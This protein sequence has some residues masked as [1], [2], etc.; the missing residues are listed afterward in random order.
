M[1]ILSLTSTSTTVTVVVMSLMVVKVWYGAALNALFSRMDTAEK[2]FMVGVFVGFLGEAIDN[3]YWLLFWASEYLGA[4]QVNAVMLEYGRMFNLPFR[5][6]AGIIAAYCHIRA[7]LE[8]SKVGGSR[9]K[10]VQRTSEWLFGASA[11]GVV[12]AFTMY[13]IAH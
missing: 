12:V 4:K 9:A 5:Q 8:F 3:A 10:G 6:F 13:Y 2:W 1:D 11:F 7:A